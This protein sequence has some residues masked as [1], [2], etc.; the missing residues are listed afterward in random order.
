MK[1]IESITLSVLR[2]ALLTAC[3]VID[4][5]PYADL[6]ADELEALYG[7]FLTPP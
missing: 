4:S 7:E 1:K 5:R 2:T 6:P 3:G